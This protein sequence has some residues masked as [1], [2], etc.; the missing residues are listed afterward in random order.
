MQNT[1]VGFFSDAAYKMVLPRRKLLFVTLE[2]LQLSILTAAMGVLTV[3]KP[4]GWRT[5]IPHLRVRL[6]S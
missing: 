6:L 1:M 5:S 4:L 2:V 3:G